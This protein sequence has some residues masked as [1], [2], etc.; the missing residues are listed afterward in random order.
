MHTYIQG[1][2]HLV[3]IHTNIHTYTHTQ[4]DSNGDYE[5]H[6]NLLNR[7]EI[8]S[9]IQDTPTGQ[10]TEENSAG[11][12]DPSKT[13]HHVT[14]RN[15]QNNDNVHKRSENNKSKSGDISRDFDVEL[16]S[17]RRDSWDGVLKKSNDSDWDGDVS[18]GPAHAGE[19]ETINE[20][21]YSNSPASQVARSPKAG[22]ER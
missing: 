6:F 14:D 1:A 13:D 12:E 5:V 11:K 15:G 16:A 2:F 3:Y 20:V 19:F 22:S 10:T 8:L 9:N 17:P 18:A 21:S 4:L 7:T